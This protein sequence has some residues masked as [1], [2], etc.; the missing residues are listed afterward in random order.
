MLDAPAS[1][2]VYRSAVAEEVHQHWNDWIQ[3]R[4]RLHKSSGRL[5]FTWTVGAIPVTDG[6]GK[7]VISRWTTS[8]ANAGECWTDSNG[9]EMQRRMK[10]FRP[11]W[12]LNQTE[13]VAGNYYPAATSVFIRDASAQLTLLTDAGQGV[14]GSLRDGEL[15]I[16]LHR[17]LLADDRLGVGEPLNETDQCPD[18]QRAGRGLIV[19]GTLSALVA[20]PAHA[21]RAW[22]PAMDEKYFAPL[23]ALAR[24][25]RAA[26][27]EV[28]FVRALPANVQ[29]LTLEQ[30]EP[31][32]R[33]PRAGSEKYP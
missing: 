18:G 27:S 13:P 3:Q 31:V 24:G 16:M 28:S 15:E 21:A 9:R 33:G 25:A 1:F 30:L 10:N 5:E 7:E 23:L 8:I 12:E 14:S 4:I 17:R 2:A 29:L 26:R 6:Q 22:R 20:R 32:E 19:R 11:T